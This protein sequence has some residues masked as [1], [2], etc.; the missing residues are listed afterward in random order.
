MSKPPSQASITA[1]KATSTVVAI[2][3]GVGGAKL[4]LG[5]QHL[6]GDRLTVVVNVADDLEHM[7]LHICPDLYREGPQ[8]R[9]AQPDSGRC[10][11][12]ARARMGDKSG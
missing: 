9:R 10:Q 8:H 2:C 6:L 4:A 1:F 12:A 7:G 3:G 5:L 11:Q